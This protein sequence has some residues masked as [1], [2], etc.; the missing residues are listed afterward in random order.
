MI[1]GQQIFVVLEGYRPVGHRI[2]TGGTVHVVW[3]F[4]GTSTRSLLF[5]EHIQNENILV[6]GSGAQIGLVKV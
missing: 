3:E 6:C 5:D 1:G 2:V 4:R